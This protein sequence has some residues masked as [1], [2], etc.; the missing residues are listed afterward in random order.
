MYMVMAAQFESLRDPLLILVT[1]P[2]GAIGV[3]LALVLTGTTLN[4]Q[5]FIGIVVLS[6][7]VVNNAIVL[8]DYNNYLKRHEPDLAPRERI[9]RASVRRFR[10]ILMTTLTTVLGMLPIAFGLGEGGE[11]QA[12]MARVVIGGLI[13]GTLITLIAIP[14]LAQA[15]E[16]RAAGD[17]DRPEPASL[18]APHKRP[19]AEPAVVAAR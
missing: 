17:A 6:G 3:I 10:P 9:V 11:L 2:L 5:S 7:I 15:V 1:I 16:R 4:V 13:S 14:L 8:I 19:R 12:P 18:P